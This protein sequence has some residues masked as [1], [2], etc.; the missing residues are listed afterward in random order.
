MYEEERSGQASSVTDDFKG[1]VQGE[2]WEKQT[3]HILSIAR[4]FY[5]R[6]SMSRPRKYYE[7]TERFGATSSKQAYK[8]WSHDTTSVLIYMA[9]IQSRYSVCCKENI[10]TIKR[11]FL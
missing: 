4:K 9:C 10:K 8:R 7:L 5:G 3:I 1:K 11:C 2:I 6:V